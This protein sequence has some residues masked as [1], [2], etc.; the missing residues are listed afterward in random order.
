MRIKCC[1]IQSCLLSY[2]QHAQRHTH[3]VPNM[4]TWHTH[5]HTTYTQTSKGLFT[6]SIFP[7]GLIAGAHE[8][9]RPC[10][11]KAL[12]GVCYS[13][14]QMPHC[15]CALC[16]YV[17]ISV[18]VSKLSRSP[19]CGFCWISYILF[20]YFLFNFHSGSPQNSFSPFP[21]LK[22]TSTQDQWVVLW[23][24]LPQD[25]H[26]SKQQWALNMCSKWWS[27]LG[28]S[29]DLY[30]ASPPV[31]FKIVLGPAI[32]SWMDELIR[33]LCSPIRMPR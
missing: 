26:T 6:A 27:S 30:P 1:L 32:I 2:T 16:M 18:S 21:L 24:R 22:V 20:I 28:L 3:T 13:D 9:D 12:Q 23:M 14:K 10:L 31:R 29:M 5:V 17:R 4:Y 25:S 33:S 11:T 15:V 7:K 8:P 19:I